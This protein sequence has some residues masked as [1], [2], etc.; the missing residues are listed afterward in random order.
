M[1]GVTRGVVVSDDQT[2][3]A[4]G[5]VEDEVEDLYRR[6]APELVK[7]A[8]SLVG[9]SEAA[10]IVSVV[11]VRCL[12]STSWLQVANQGDGRPGDG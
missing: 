10:D 11:T 1:P 3:T 6:Y 7:F 9:P 4:E 8:T 12:R 2:S 5:R